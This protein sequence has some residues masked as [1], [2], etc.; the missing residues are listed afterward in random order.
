ME[1]KVK[2]KDIDYCVQKKDALIVYMINGKIWVCEKQ[3]ELPNSN[4]FFVTLKLKTN[5]RG[6]KND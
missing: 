3:Q 4:D 2:S 1:V 5:K 6:G